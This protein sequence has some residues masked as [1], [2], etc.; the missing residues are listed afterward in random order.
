MKQEDLLLEVKMKLRRALLIFFSICLLIL[1]GAYSILLVR[2]H[3]RPLPFDQKKWLHASAQKRT[4]MVDSLRNSRRLIGM[5]YA[6]V[7]NLLGPPDDPLRPLNLLNSE[8]VACCTY[9]LG[10]RGFELIDLYWPGN[11]FLIVNFDD[12][13][14]VE[15]TGIGSTY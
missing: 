8:H 12:H 10:D 4:C 11:E 7:V 13:S 2:H 1:G 9:T 5:T 14:H 6:E 15:A 3:Y